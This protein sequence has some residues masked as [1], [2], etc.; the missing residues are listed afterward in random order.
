MLFEARFGPAIQAGEVTVTYRRWKRRQAVAGHRYRT[1]VGYLEVDAVDVVEQASITARDARAAGYPS[2]EA[3]AA[4]L[5]GTPDLPLYRVRFH[6][7]D[8][9]DPRD[10]LAAAATLG[11]DE[12]I[13]IS[14]RLKRLDKAS[15]SGPWTAA[16]LDLIASRPGVRAADLAASVDRETQPFKLDVRKLKGLGLTVSLER[17]Y[18]LS[19][20]GEAYRALRPAD[21]ASV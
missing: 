19:P 20:R 7:V 14:A 9:P 4:D 16:T 12:V 1:V 2:V 3:L 13:E 21:E 17:G 11:P 6:V 18:R 15:R 10:E 8:G 5:R